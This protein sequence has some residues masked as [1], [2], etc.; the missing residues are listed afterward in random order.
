[1]PKKE[2]SLVL[3]KGIFKQQLNTWQAISL[4]TSGT[5]GAGIL[6]LPYVVA[7]IGLI[8]GLLYILFIGLFIM[9]LNLMIGEVVSRLKTDL[10]L[11]GLAKKYLGKF[12]GYLMVVLNYSLS[13]GILVVYIIGEGESLAMLFHGDKFI[14][15]LIFFFVGL[16]LLMAGIKTIKS[17]ELFLSLGIL[18][19]VLLI[20][21]SSLRYLN[22]NNLNYVDW[23]YLFLPYGVI[24]FAFSGVNTIPEAHSLLKN[25]D[26]E[27]KKVIIKSSLLVMIIY[28]LFVLIV[29]GVTGRTTTEIATIGLGLVI[30]KLMLVLGNLFAILAM[31]TSFLMAGLS[32]RDSLRWDFKMNTTVATL[33]V[34][35]VPFMIFILGL[36]SFIKAIDI[37]GGVFVSLEMLVLLLVYWRAKQLGDLKTSKFNLHYIWLLIAILTFIFSGGVI[38]SLV[39]IT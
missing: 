7:K 4:I 26:K 39:N 11:V 24:L 2:N 32:F 25:K 13:F 5:I 15:S 30:G 38:Y 10:Q 37:V 28:M 23:H 1:M 34:G 27:F 6:G 35:F 18:L 14:Y 19:V 29:V 9:G 22:F 31:G 36:R 8:P 20:S 33:I 3:Y 12:G 21:F 16:L 17:I